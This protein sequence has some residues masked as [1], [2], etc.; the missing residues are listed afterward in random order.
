MSANRDTSDVTNRDVPDVSRDI[1]QK[2]ASTPTVTEPI[3]PVTEPI[4]PDYKDA[5]NVT[6]YCTVPYRTVPNRSEKTT[7]AGGGGGGEHVPEP[8]APSPEPEQTKPDKTPCPI[9]LW[10]R[11]P[12][13]T[14]QSMDTFPIPRAGQEYL[15][16]GFSGRY[17]GR[18]DQ[19]RTLDQW[20]S[21]AVR[22]IQ[23]DWNDPKKRPQPLA[24]PA[25]APGAP[26]RVNAPQDFSSPLSR[27]LLERKIQ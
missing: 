15:C 6:L 3:A 21:S 16:R 2:G 5:E 8:A 7:A 22:A 9:D 20:V 19:L 13:R 25:V 12:E 10:E 24:G 4:A 23:S 1:P 17:A 14:K 26:S 27:R 18:T 11:M